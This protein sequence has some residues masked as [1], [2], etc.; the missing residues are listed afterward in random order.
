MPIGVKGR[1]SEATDGS[2]KG[3]KQ[4][5]CETQEAIT[6]VG[7]IRRSAIAKDAVIGMAASPAYR[8][9]HAPT[10]GASARSISMASS[11]TPWSTVS[12][13]TRQTGGS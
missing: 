11:E 8:Y 5:S 9:A 7:E 10:K 1:R 2:P 4:E 6:N 13:R 12:F 3:S